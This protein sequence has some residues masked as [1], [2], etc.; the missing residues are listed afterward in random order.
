MQRHKMYLWIYEPTISIFPINRYTVKEMLQ[1]GGGS[2]F[3]MPP[4][5]PATEEQ[6]INAA[7][8]PTNFDWR[9][10]NGVNFVSDVR[11]QA[12]CGSCF[13]FASAG[14]RDELF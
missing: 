6:K 13:A 7:A 14:K 11:D 2:S 1:R 4:T 3:P 9:D 10:M 8:L 12:S 5:A